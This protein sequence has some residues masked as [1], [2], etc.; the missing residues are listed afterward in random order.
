M[1]VPYGKYLLVKIIEKPKKHGI[2]LMQEE[3]D[4]IVKC[5]FLCE[6]CDINP[7]FTPYKAYVLYFRRY[8]LR[9]CVDK[10]QKIYL[11]KEECLLGYE[12][13]DDR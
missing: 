10:E 3:E 6:G 13:K 1:I 2:I 8:E 4:P 9:D 11:I 12:V 7:G 5:E